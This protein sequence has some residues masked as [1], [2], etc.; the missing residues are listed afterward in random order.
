MKHKTWFRLMLKVVGVLLIGLGV[1]EVITTLL[2][3]LQLVVLSDWTFVSNYGSVG[4]AGSTMFGPEDLF[5]VLMILGPAVQV[6]LG[7]YLLFGGTWLVDRCIPSNRPYCPNCGYDLSHNTGAR[8]S[9][10]GVTLPP[11]DPA[12]TITREEKP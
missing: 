1:P 7:L 12:D 5:Q 4:G 6:L 11:R 2:W 9:E 3:M 8:C 10:C